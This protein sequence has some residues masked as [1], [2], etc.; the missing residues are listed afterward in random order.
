MT[1][2]G[3][4]VPQKDPGA[5]QVFINTE[6]QTEVHSCSCAEGCNN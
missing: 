3:G 6:G 4:G 1:Q 5:E 2:A